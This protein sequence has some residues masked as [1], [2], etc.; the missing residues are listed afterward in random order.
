MDLACC[1]QE[2]L[3]LRAT[4]LARPCTVQGRHD[5]QCD[6]VCRREYEDGPYLYDSF[7]EGDNELKIWDGSMQQSNS[8]DGSSIEENG[9]ATDEESELEEVPEWPQ[10]EGLE[11]P[12]GFIER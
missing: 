7:E 8:S 9:A 1:I 5:Q 10:L 2:M 4:E 3:A 6:R 11:L 12:P